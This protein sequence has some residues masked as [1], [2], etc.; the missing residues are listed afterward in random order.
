MDDDAYANRD[1]A[2]DGARQ[3]AERFATGEVPYR[4]VYQL[5]REAYLDKLDELIE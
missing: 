2:E 5:P 4:S 1:A 3:L